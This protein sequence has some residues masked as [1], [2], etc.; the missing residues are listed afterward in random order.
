MTT[1][2]NPFP[3]IV[4][5]GIDAEK[6]LDATPSEGSVV[7]ELPNSSDIIAIGDPVWVRSADESV[8]QYRGPATASSTTQITCQ[9]PLQDAVGASATAWKPTASV[10]F[11]GELRDTQRPVRNSGIVTVPTMSG[12]VFQYQAA[13]LQDSVSLNVWDHNMTKNAILYQEWLDF[14]ETRGPLPFNLGYYSLTR[15]RGETPKVNVREG[16]HEGRVINVFTNALSETFFI[17]D[18]ALYVES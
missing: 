11:F 9:I 16:E 13:D 7:M 2:I 4:A 6:T 17:L 14:L 12:T 3:P 10:R 8:I 15:R 5:Y 18:R 1:A